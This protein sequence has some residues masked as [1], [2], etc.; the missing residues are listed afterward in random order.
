MIAL[1]LIVVARQLCVITAAGA[2]GVLLQVTL[3]VDRK[4]RVDLLVVG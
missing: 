3:P 2:H 4:R 1:L